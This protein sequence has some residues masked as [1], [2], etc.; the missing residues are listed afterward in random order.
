MKKIVSIIGISLIF[1]GCTTT[2][3]QKF[4]NIESATVNQEIFQQPAVKEYCQRL[5]DKIKSHMYS[6]PL[7]VGYGGV[8]VKL[9]LSSN[10]KLRSILLIK[11]KSDA[12]K[13]L[14]NAVIKSFKR[15]STFE[16]FPQEL[17]EKYR[18]LDFHMLIHF[19]PPG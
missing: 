8:S 11:S 13:E 7:I 1:I 9:R 19:D 14:K 6:D 5:K 17:Q 12:S 16:P 4:Q 3:V 2:N 10:G 15:I 18:S